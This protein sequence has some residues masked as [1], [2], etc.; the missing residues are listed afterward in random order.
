[1]I[2][3]RQGPTDCL[4]QGPASPSGPKAPVQSPCGQV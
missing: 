4:D 2:L 3:S 1:V